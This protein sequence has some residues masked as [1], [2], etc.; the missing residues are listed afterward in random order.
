MCDPSNCAAALHP[1]PPSPSRSFKPCEQQDA[2]ELY[3]QLVNALAEAD[4]PPDGELPFVDQVFG[5]QIATKVGGLG[6]GG[7]QV[8]CRALQ[9]G[10]AGG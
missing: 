6:A 8:T 3:V 2:Q 5:W 4:T 9:G 1:L 7:A 10:W